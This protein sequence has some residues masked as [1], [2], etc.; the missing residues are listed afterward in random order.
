MLTSMEDWREKLTIDNENCFWL[1]SE[2]NEN[3]KGVS[4][5]MP[6]VQTNMFSFVI[7]SGIIQ[8][9]KNKKGI[10]HLKFAQILREEFKI[11]TMASF[12]ND[13]IRIVTHRD[14]DREDLQ[15]TK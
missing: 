3:V 8:K 9:Q 4:V 14:V 6:T 13:S 5:N 15:F 11:I 1:A 7:D 10:D 12:K 2:L